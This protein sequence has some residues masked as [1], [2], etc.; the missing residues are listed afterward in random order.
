MLELKVPWSMSAISE[1]NNRNH[2]ILKL[3]DVFPNVS[4]TV[5]ETERVLLVKIV[6]SKYELTDELPNDVTL[7]K[8]SALHGIKV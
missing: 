2:N 5:S 4:F 8:T 6:D 1:N 7:K 3:E